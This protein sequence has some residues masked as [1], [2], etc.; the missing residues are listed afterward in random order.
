MQFPHMILT[1]TSYIP[2]G[3][4]SR[5]SEATSGPQTPKSRNSSALGSGCSSLRLRRP[6][7]NANS[8]IVCR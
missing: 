1:R 5:S 4:I 3:T 2:K 7:A 6:I 8:S